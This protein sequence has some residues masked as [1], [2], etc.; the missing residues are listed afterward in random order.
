MMRNENLLTVDDYLEGADVHEEQYQPITGAPLA[1]V[2][3]VLLAIGHGV[4]L[5]L[6]F[7]LGTSPILNLIIHIV[8]VVISAILVG[9]MSRAGLDTRFARLAYI[10]TAV[11]GVVGAI[12]T[13]FSLIQSIFYLRFRTSFEEWY[14]SIFPR[15]TL[16]NPETIAEEIELGRDE[17]PQ[18]YTV[19]SFVD[20]MEIG[21]EQQKRDALSKMTASFHPVFSK[22]FKRAIADD[23]SAIRV[24][25]ATA[26]TRIENRFHERLLKIENL[27]REHPNNPVILKALADHYDDYAYTGLLDEGREIVN[28]EKAYSHFLEY[29]NLRPED[30]SVRP[31]IGRL[32]IRMDRHEE[33]VKWFK[34][35]LDEGYGSDT[36]K[37]WYIESLYHTGDF[38]ALRQAASSYQVDLNAHQETQPEI[39]ESVYLWA[40]AGMSDKQVRAAG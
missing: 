10:S 31:K 19:M 33:A 37:M 21:S 38:E 5:Y 39:T 27:Y 30:S 4:N 7:G 9:V 34:R 3:C 32:L 26:I 20:V 35:C 40:Q 2:F 25:A 13:L 18:Q 23:S 6:L 24:Q 15:T 22:A 12:G 14:Q 11:M 36:I 1:A 8:L 29:L 28:R 16:S 17:H